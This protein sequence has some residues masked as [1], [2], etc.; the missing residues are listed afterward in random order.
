MKKNILFFLSLLFTFLG[1]TN[2]TVDINKNDELIKKNLVIVIK[3]QNEMEKRITA[4]KNKIN[5]QEKIIN[6]L[7]KELTFNIKISSQNRKISAQKDSQRTKKIILY[8]LNKDTAA[9]NKKN[10]AVKTY[11]A[12]DIVR[13]IKIDNQK[14]YLDNGLWINCK[15]A[16]RI[17]LK[18]EK[19]ESKYHLKFTFYKIGTYMANARTEPNPKNR[20]NIARVYKRGDIVKVVNFVKSND[21]GVWAHLDNNLYINKKILVP[22][23]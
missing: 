11:K 23:Y 7:K 2:N 13:V 6:K 5:A 8:R 14:C 10:K 19:K 21:G 20:D 4:L 12:G 22:L 16:S 15:N 18:K 3:K 17:D 1:A 9:Y